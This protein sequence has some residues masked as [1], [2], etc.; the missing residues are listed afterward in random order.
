[1]AIRWGNLKTTTWEKDIEFEGPFQLKEL[2]F[3]AYSKEPVVF[4]ILLRPM[5]KIEQPD[6][7]KALMFGEADKMTKDFLQKHPERKCWVGKARKDAKLF[8]C[9]K[10]MPGSTSEERARTVDMLNEQIRPICEG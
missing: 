4:G 2:D 9:I 6:I 1:M 8:I 3:S 10:R 5:P 7:Y